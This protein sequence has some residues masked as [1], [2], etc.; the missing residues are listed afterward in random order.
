MNCNSV[1]IGQR[2]Y[3]SNVYNGRELMEIVGI[4]K[5]QVELKG[6]YSG[7][8]NNVCQSDWETLEGVI[9]YEQHIANQIMEFVE[10]GTLNTDDIMDLLSRYRIIIE[11]E[12]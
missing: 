6:D 1:K 9:T 8:T 2:V 4:R 3:H 10:I 12:K 7:G 5:N 11:I